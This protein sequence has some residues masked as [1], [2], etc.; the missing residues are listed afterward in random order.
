MITLSNDNINPITSSDIPFYCMDIQCQTNAVKIGVGG[1][2]DFVL[3]PTETY[4]TYN[5]NMI[6]F[7]IQNQTA[8]SNAKIVII[9]TVPNKLVEDAL[10]QGFKR[11]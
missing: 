10:K 4:W 9:A 6:D 2:M 7:Q 8:G 5:A 1:A 11:F 3:F